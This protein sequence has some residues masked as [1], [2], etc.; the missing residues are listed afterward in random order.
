[1]RLAK[2]YSGDDYG[3]HFPLLDGTEVALAFTQGDPDRPVIVG[4]MHDSQH[5][6][7]VNS[8]NHTRNLI[9]T[10]AG[11]VQRM[12]DKEGAEHIHQRTPFQASE[13][14]LGHMVDEGR[15]E[16]GQ[17][18]ELRTD[19]AAAVRGAKGVLISAEA[20]PN[21]AGQ[22]LDMKGAQEQL[23]R[24]FERVQSLQDAV[25]AAEATLVELDKQKALYAEALDGLKR[26]AILMS[27]PCG[28]GL[29]SGEHLHVNAD[30][31]LITT[32]GASFDVGVMRNFAVAA[33]R[34]VSLFAQAQGVKV[35]AAKQDV[36][37]QARTGAM[38]LSASKDLQLNSVDGSIVAASHGALTLTSGGAYIKIDGGNIELGC[39]G[40]ITLKCGSFHW[41]G[42]DNL[43]VPLHAMPIG[44]C[45]E[46]LLNAHSGAESIT[47]VA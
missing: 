4:A 17:G 2:P 41:T 6:D 43:S 31:N 16:R 39:P 27:A 44:T 47:E 14:N 7:L 20:Q 32:A 8:G 37:L 46:C 34:Q 15:K 28:I 38:A 11:N 29:T 18:A 24:A 45:K 1:V 3:H 12:E 9:R 42:P 33:G 10:A 26:A 35:V 22:Q 21:A 25:Y 40:G 36:V 13:L 30:Q 23:R 5:R 19:G